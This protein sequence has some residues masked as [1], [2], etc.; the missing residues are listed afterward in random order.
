MFHSLKSWPILKPWSQLSLAEN[1]EVPWASFSSVSAVFK[2]GLSVSYS[3]CGSTGKPINWDAES[4]L[5]D[6]KYG[7]TTTS[8]SP[9]PSRDAATP[10][11][12]SKSPKSKK[13][14]KSDLSINVEPKDE[15]EI[16]KETNYLDEN[17]LQARSRLFDNNMWY[18]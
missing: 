4:L 12:R 15:V 14:E 1:L 7:F 3:S 6:R 16:E 5:E 18:Y 17:P 10:K 11:G 9:T 2:D 13:K 8:G